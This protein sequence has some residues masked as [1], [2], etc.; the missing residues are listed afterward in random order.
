MCLHQTTSK[1]RHLNPVKAS[2]SRLDYEV[3]QFA[4]IKAKITESSAFSVALHPN[5]VHWAATGQNAKVKLYSL[6]NHLRPGAGPNDTNEDS[7]ESAQGLGSLDKVVDTGKS[8]FGMCVKYVSVTI[9]I[10]QISI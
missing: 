10:H 3:Y 4:N 5:G 2:I 8:K 9:D 6:P 1:H 7:E